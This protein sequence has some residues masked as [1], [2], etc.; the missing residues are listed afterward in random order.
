[1]IRILKK[2][3]CVLAAIPFLLASTI[4]SA[5]EVPGFNGFAAGIGFSGAAVEIA[6]TETDPEGTAVS[7]KSLEELSHPVIFGEARF[8]SASRLGLTVGLDFIPGSANFVT[9]SKTDTDLTSTIDGTNSGTSTV[10]GKMKNHATLYI[11]P[12][13]SITDVFSVYLSAGYILAQVEADAKLVTS[14][15]FVKR[16]VTNGTRLGAGIMTQHDNGFFVKLEG[17]VSDYEQL[18]F[19]TS[20]GTK[21]TANVETESATILI[22]KAF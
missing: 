11:Q 12:T 8:K 19:N 16:Q 4:S 1:M 21:V 22:G 3:L 5:F 2:Y 9:E 20:E 14:T 7:G 17:N 6:G 13:L 18:L 10:T 15:N